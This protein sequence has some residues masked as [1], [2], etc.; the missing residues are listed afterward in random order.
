[1]F[2]L[3]AGCIRICFSVGG[4]RFS[5][6]W[7]YFGDDDACFGTAKSEVIVCYFWMYAGAFSMNVWLNVPHNHS[8][9]FIMSDTDNKKATKG[10]EH[11]GSKKRA[12]AAAA[13]AVA[14]AKAAPAATDLPEASEGNDI[15]LDTTVEVSSSPKS[16]RPKH[17]CKASTSSTDD[18]AVDGED[19]NNTLTVED[20]PIDTKQDDEEIVA[21]PTTSPAIMP[22]IQA[23]PE[24]V[25]T[26]CGAARKLAGNVAM[27]IKGPP[28]VLTTALKPESFVLAMIT[29]DVSGSQTCW[30]F[31]I[32][33]LGPC[34]A[35]WRMRHLSG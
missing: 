27:S 31:W 13:A 12:A 14:V 2:G 5:V 9:L 29:N 18:G 33:R 22:T 28:D 7:C 32:Q 19:T 4:G 20:A 17:E 25:L 15:E 26:M 6:Y 24:T 23:T 16:K 21:P 3:Q 1:M 34:L 10:T 30:L 35:K 11:S 8:Q